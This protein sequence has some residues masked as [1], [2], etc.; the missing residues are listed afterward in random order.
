MATKMAQYSSSP[1]ASPVQMRTCT[2]DQL[3]RTYEMNSRTIT[4]HGDTSSQ[5]DEDQAFSKTFLVWEECPSE[6]KLHVQSVTAW[7][8]S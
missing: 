8:W 2:E 7:S 3:R 5:A 4:Y 6:S 1:P